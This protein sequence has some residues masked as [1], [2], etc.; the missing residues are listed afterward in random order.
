MSSSDESTTL[1]AAAAVGT[2]VAALP[3]PALAPAAGGGLAAALATGSRRRNAG[4]GAV[5]GFGGGLLYITGWAA[6]VLVLSGTFP[7][8]LPDGG[9]FEGFAL[10]VLVLDVLGGAIGGVLGGGLARRAR[11]RGST[12]EQSGHEQPE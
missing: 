8:Q 4:L 1:R 10:F 5:V 9:P 6:L 11:D 7:P 2:V 12:S 3:V